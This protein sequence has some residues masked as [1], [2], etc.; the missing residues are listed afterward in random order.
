VV[1]LGW[2]EPAATIA[3]VQDEA[4]EVVL[5]MNQKHILFPWPRDFSAL[6]S[7]SK[8]SLPTYFPPFL[9]ISPFLRPSPHFSLTP[10]LELGRVSELE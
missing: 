2:S 10:S 9:P 7:A 3:L 4:V 8:F 5:G 1:D 6:F